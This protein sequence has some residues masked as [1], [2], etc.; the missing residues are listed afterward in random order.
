MLDGVRLDARALPVPEARPRLLGN[1]E[2]PHLELGGGSRRRPLQ[3]CP[4]TT[5]QCGYRVSGIS[6]IDSN[7]APLAFAALS[8]AEKLG[9]SYTQNE[10]LLFAVAYEVSK[11]TPYLRS[12]LAATS[13]EPERFTR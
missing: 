7:G 9:A 5:P 6:A 13:G 2:C 10:S 1:E 4:L 3:H 12:L 8:T 11:V